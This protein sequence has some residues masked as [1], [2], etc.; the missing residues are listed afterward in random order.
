MMQSYIEEPSVRPFPGFDPKADAQLLRDAMKGFGTDEDKIIAVLCQRSNEQRQKIIEIYHNEFG[1]DLIEDLKK[2]LGGK[3]EKL[4]LALMWR[5]AEYNASELHNAISGLGTDEEVLVEI[6]LTKTDRENDEIKQAY[7]RLYGK[8]LEQDVASDTSKDFRRLL[9]LIISGIRDER[10]YDPNLAKQM[11]EALFNAGE[12]KMIGTDEEMFNNI[13][14]KQ[15]QI[16][17]RLI[18]EEYKHLSGKTIEQAIEAE[19]S[20]PLKEGIMALVKSIQNRPS[21]F[22]ERLQLAMK[23]AGT[24]DATLIRILVSRSEL[25]LNTIKREYERLYGKTL[26]SAVKGETSGDYKKGLLAIIGRS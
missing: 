2:E 6:I 11:A 10:M 1:R 25:D 19:L 12:G 18:F 5:P 13:F 20:G 7:Q 8:S 15:S 17:L 9:V 22:A 23:G 21:Y 26:E 14:G 16:Q 24:D 4:I 3:F